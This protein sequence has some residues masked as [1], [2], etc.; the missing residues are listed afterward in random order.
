MGEYVV[1]VSAAGGSAPRSSRNF[2]LECKLGR[3]L[4]FAP[5]ALNELPG[6]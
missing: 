1:L 3:R 5:S 4:E 6:P 2:E